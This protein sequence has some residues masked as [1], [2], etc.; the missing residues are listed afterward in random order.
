LAS[1]ARWRLPPYFFIRVMKFFSALSKS[2][3]N[4]KSGVVGGRLVRIRLF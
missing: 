2:N 3:V 1:S 4:E